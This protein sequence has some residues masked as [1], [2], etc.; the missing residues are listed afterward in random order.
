MNG[1][2]NPNDAEHLPNSSLLFGA[3]ERVTSCVQVA[4]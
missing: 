1:R 4:A 2:M 3:A